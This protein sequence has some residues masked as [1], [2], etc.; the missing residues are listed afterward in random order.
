MLKRLLLSF[1][2]LPAL[3]AAECGVVRAEGAM[4][5][6]VG[7]NATNCFSGAGFRE[8]F[9]ANLNAALEAESAARA[10]ERQA[11]LARRKPNVLVP[12]PVAPGGSYYGQR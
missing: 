12:D 4:N 3:A 5:I 9:L 10:R 2:L 7:R 1:L 6:V 8:T 11:P